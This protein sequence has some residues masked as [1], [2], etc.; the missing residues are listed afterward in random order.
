MIK[1]KIEEIVGRIALDKVVKKKTEQK[2]SKPSVLKD[3][4]D[5][6]DD[7]RMEAFVENG[8]IVIKIKKNI[9]S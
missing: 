7:F 3:L 5:C 4:L 8:E 9:E 2:E 1:N 6:P